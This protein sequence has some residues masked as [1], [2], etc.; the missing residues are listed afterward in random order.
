[1]LPGLLGQGN[2]LRADDRPQPT[3]STTVFGTTMPIDGLRGQVYELLYGMTYLPYFTY[4]KPLTTVYTKSLNIPAQDAMGGFPG[5]PNLKD[6]FAIDYQGTFWI[7][8]PGLY[9]F[10]LTS[11][12]GSKLYIDDALVINNDGIHLPRTEEGKIDLKKGSHRI[13]VS[14]FEGTREQ[15]ALVLCVARLNDP[16][17]EVFNTDDFK[18]PTGVKGVKGAKKSKSE[19]CERCGAGKQWKMPDVTTPPGTFPPDLFPPP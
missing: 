16:T 3:F 11:D 6:W 12:D 5:L 8:E 7:S 10:Q 4:M 2:A 1:M 18:K 9:H 15:F 13:R 19:C 17:W 14:Y